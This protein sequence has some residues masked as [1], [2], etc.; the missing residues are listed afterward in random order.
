MPPLYFCSIRW[1]WF[2]R[3]INLKFFLSLWL[4]LTFQGYLQCCATRGCFNSFPVTEKR[5]TCIKSTSTTT[6]LHF[7]GC[8]NLL[9]LKLKSVMFAMY[10]YLRFSCNMC[11]VYVFVSII[12]V[13]C[14][15]FVFVYS[16][17]YL[18]LCFCTQCI[19]IQYNAMPP[20]TETVNESSS[21]V[22]R[23]PTF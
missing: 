6:H 3:L 23:P 14:I 17:L 22:V 1:I 18:Y 16:C 10:L 4:S 15:H 21:C 11:I 7:H 9:K 2:Y 12:C 5:S 20:N 13:L 19:H 8:I